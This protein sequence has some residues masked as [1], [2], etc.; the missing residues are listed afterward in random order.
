MPPVPAVPPSHIPDSHA[1]EC[2]DI[3]KHASFYFS[4]RRD[5][6]KSVDIIKD[7]FQALCMSLHVTTT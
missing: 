6:S 2:S 3:I 1:D 5:M 4:A 7:Q